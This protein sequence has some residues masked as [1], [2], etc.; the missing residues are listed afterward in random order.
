MLLIKNA[1]ILTMEES[2]FENG[3]IIAEDGKI[4]ALGAMNELNITEDRCDDVYDANG[5]YALPGF[6]EAHCHVG[7]W[8]YGHGSE[9]ADGN[10]SSDVV[11]PQLRA[12]DSINPFDLSLSKAL[13]AGVTTVVTGPGSA[14]IIGGQFAAIKTGGRWIDEMI[15]KAPVAM[16]AALGENPKKAHGSKG[17]PKTRMASAAIMREAFFKAKEYVRKQ[18]AYLA[19]NTKPCPEPDFKMEAL[20]EVIRKNIPLKVH[21]HRADDICTAIRIA[22]EFDIRLT[23]EHCTEGHLIAPYLAEKKIPVMLGPTFGVSDKPETKN[24]SYEVYTEMEK[25]GISFA[26]ITDHD[27]NPI[28]DLYLFAT[29]CHKNGLSKM[30]ALRGITINAARNTGIDDR[31]GSLAPGKDA[32]VVI[33]S[34]ELLSLDT[35]VEAVFLDGRQV[36]E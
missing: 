24:T 5:A 35:K 19:D 6:V 14:N 13:H 20:A 11:T 22:E 17:A 7:M 26:I 31:V 29:L 18:D 25:A 8:S 23:I 33:L 27:V 28:E 34:G 12:I 9:S 4:K 30:G 16:K 36:K 2:E 10:E 15:I 32:N 1:H 3:Y 21:A